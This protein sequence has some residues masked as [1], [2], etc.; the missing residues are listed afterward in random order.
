[1]LQICLCVKFI[2]ILYGKLCMILGFT[3]EILN[4]SNSEHDR[5]FFLGDVS[6]LLVLVQVLRRHLLSTNMVFY[7]FGG[8]LLHNSL[9]IFRIFTLVSPNSNFLSSWWKLIFTVKKVAVVLDLFLLCINCPFTNLSVKHVNIHC[10]VNLQVCE[11]T[12]LADGG[13]PEHVDCCIPQTL[14]SWCCCC[15]VK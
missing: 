11:T 14:Y 15:M 2:F 1:M 4:W 5:S 3:V 8:C 13:Y 7:S 9:L 12:C 10:D 6:T